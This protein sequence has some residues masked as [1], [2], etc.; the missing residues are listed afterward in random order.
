MLGKILLAL[1]TV[2]MLGA[3]P[4]NAEQVVEWSNVTAAGNGCPSSSAVLTA[5]PQ[6]DELAWSSDSFGFSLQGPSSIARFCRLSATAK[7]K[8]GFYLDRVFQLVSFGAA[9]STEGSSFS[10]GAKARFFGND[11]EEIKRSYPSG[12][13]FDVPRITFYRGQS[14]SALV[15]PSFFCQE[16]NDSGL[17][18]GTVS[19]TSQVT[20]SLG[21]ATVGIQ[22][23]TVSYR[24]VF[25]WK[26]CL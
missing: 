1:V 24:V 5:T 19:A 3:H 9:K 22:G 26:P 12:T 11:L 7:L 14:F 4:A 10:I 8:P 6:G 17:F 16:K 18:Q 2:T 23:Q 21:I 13:A 15:P 20:D 25:R